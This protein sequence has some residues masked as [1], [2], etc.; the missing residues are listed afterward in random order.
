MLKPDWNLTAWSA[1][2]VLVIQMLKM[3]VYGG[4]EHVGM[5]RWR[6]FIPGK[7]CRNRW[8]RRSVG[9]TGTS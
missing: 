6:S 3:C 7:R 9:G 2:R 4:G 5:E 8:S 1:W